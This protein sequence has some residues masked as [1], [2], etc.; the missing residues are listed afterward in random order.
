MRK[1][2]LVL[3]AIAVTFFV[4]FLTYTFVAQK[5]L[6]TLARDF[7]TEKTLVY[8]KPLVGIAEESLESPLVRRLIS[9]DQATVVRKEIADYR[10]DPAAYVADLTRRQIREEP[11]EDAN[12]LIDKVI[13]VKRAIRTYYDN[14]LNALVED[15]RIFSLSNLLAGLIAFVLAY[16]SSPEVRK[17]IVWFS[18]LM[19]V[20]VLYC[21]SMYVDDLTF[22]RILFRTHPG[23][24]YAGILCVATV[25][26]YLDYGRHGMPSNDSSGLAR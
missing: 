12:P 22:F 26:L 23:W 18:F 6:D 20:A 14:T 4:G 8:S 25:G 7:V 9:D 17:P 21:T 5:H 15:L 16:R 24:W 2:T 3:N 1:T 13:S 11:T 19:F 10:H